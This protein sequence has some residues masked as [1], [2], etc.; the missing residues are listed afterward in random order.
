M[1]VL[2]VKEFFIMQK[3]VFNN[4][5]LPKLLTSLENLPD[6]PRTTYNTSELILNAKEVIGKL[7]EKNYTFD[8]IAQL[9]FVENGIDIT[10]STIKREYQ[11]LISQPRVKK[12][13]KSK[14]NSTGTTSESTPLNTKITG[15]DSQVE[16]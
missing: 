13:T 10:G 5:E 2:I 15:A 7:L 3:R 8:E 14:S 9:G 6:K 12:R 4:I 16:E 11:K 1:Q